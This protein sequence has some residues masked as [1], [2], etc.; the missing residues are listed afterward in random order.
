[1]F[2]RKEEYVNE[3]N[4]EMNFT[5]ERWFICVNIILNNVLAMIIKIL[6]SGNSLFKILI[7]GINE[8][9]LPFL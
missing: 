7:L 4:Y 3:E 5:E 6:I 8:K 1:M 2:K 9:V